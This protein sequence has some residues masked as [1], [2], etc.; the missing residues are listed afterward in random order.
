MNQ[1]KS[2]NPNLVDYCG[3]LERFCPAETNVDVDC[4]GMLYH[5]D[6][7][8]ITLTRI[9]IVSEKGPR[10]NTRDEFK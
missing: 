2:D 1:A 5:A 6:A 7:E 9:M 3:L 4:L 8:I 10:V